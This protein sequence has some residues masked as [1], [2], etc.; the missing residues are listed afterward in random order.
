M[1]KKDLVENEYQDQQW[2]I[3]H[4][5]KIFQDNPNARISAAFRLFRRE[6]HY[7]LFGDYILIASIMIALKKLNILPTR[8][9][10]NYACNFSEEFKGFTKKGKMQYLDNV[11]TILSG[12]SKIKGNPQDKD[13]K[14]KTTK[15]LA[16]GHLK[17]KNIKKLTK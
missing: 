7:T 15:S 17:V 6:K 14:A 2:V 10:V 5:L 8:Q 4:A 3:N 11:F 16:T 1:K 13:L 9:E 12:R